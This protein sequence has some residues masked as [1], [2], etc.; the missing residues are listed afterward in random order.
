[1]CAQEITQDDDLSLSDLQLALFDLHPASS[2]DELELLDYHR[3]LS[4][5]D[6]GLSDDGLGLFNL[7]PGLPDD[8][9]RLED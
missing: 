2:D 8:H 9:S 3:C 5:D 6:L 4:D 7:H 1:M